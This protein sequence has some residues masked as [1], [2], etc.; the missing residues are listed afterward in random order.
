MEHEPEGV[1]SNGDAGGCCGEESPVK[2]LE[3]ISPTAATAQDRL[4]N[5][6]QGWHAMNYLMAAQV[7][8]KK[9]LR[10]S[11]QGCSGGVAMQ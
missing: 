9:S 2:A 5:A 11:L 7:V 8:T 6:L 4:E 1:S 3:A 10:D